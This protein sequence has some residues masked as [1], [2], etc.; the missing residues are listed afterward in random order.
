MGKV[1]DNKAAPPVYH[2]IIA[3]LGNATRTYADCQA[4]V[5]T[6]CTE[7]GAVQILSVKTVELQK[8]LEQG[9]LL[10]SRF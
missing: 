2:F 7:N 5:E 9:H 3:L 4:L 6:T 10:F 1:K 8:H